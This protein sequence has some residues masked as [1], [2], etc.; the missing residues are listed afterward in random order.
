VHQ[1][2]SEWTKQVPRNKL[3]ASEVIVA[4]AA[5]VSKT[6]A[7]RATSGDV[8]QLALAI[9]RTTVLKFSRQCSASPPGRPLPRLTAVSC[10]SA[11]ICFVNKH[12]H[13][14]NTLIYKKIN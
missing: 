8:R 2:G 7:R 1:F 6:R 9:A 12:L 14:L 13:F 4:H 5:G 11:N 3:A 10:G